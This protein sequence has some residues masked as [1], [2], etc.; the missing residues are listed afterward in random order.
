MQTCY[1]CGEQVEDNVL[2]CPKCGA[3][4]KRYGPPVREN[5]PKAEAS[6]QNTG[7]GAAVFQDAVGRLRLRTSVKVLLILGVILSLYTALS[8]ACVLMVYNDQTFYL[9]IWQQMPQLSGLVDTLM[10]LMESVQA[11]YVLF[12][13]YP[14]LLTAQAAMEIW[15]LC[16]KRKKAFRAAAVATAAV[17]FVSIL[18]GGILTA[19]LY[20]AALLL[21]WI[22]LKRDGG[23]L[24]D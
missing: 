22:L 7:A 5:E 1:N 20:S 12:L 8:Y 23:C 10:L 11:N 14:L 2:I 15:F 19:I 24:L 16:S 9:S 17:F 6:P 18:F 4:V 3:L 21:A 13:L